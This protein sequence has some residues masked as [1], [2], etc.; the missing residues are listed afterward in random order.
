[1]NVWDG[2]KQRSTHLATSAVVA[3]VFVAGFAL[4]SQHSVGAQSPFQPPEGA[5]EDF[6]AFW[7]VYNLIQDNYVDP[8]GDELDQTK[9]VDGAIRGMMDSLGDQ[10]SGY[11]DAEMFPMINQELEGEIQ[12]IGVT[13]QT[14]EDTGAIQ[15]VSVMSDSPAQAAGIQTGDIFARVDGEDATVMNQMELAQ[16]VRGPEGSTVQITMLRDDELIDFEV[17]RARIVIPMIESQVIDDTIGYV[18]LNQFGPTARPDIDAAIE[19]M[20]T[21]SLEG[22]I[23]DLRGNPG[24]LLSSAIDVGSAFVDEG[25]ILIE[26]FGGGREQIFDANGSYLNLDIPLVVLVDE[27]SASASELVAGA[28]QDNEQATIIGETTFGKGTVQTWQPLVNGGGVRLTVARWLTPDRHWIHEFGITPDYIVEWNPTTSEEAND[29][30]QDVQLHAAIDY[31]L[32]G[33]VPQPSVVEQSADP[34]ALAG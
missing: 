17:E 8:E 14:V 19:E 25:P 11:M 27:S 28:L 2:L 32:H 3:I 13:I 1:M 29:P 21:D 33:T 31:L 12:G 23:F 30:A 16:H 20:D 24:G 26:D 15:V 4:G 7:Q 18:R 10:F 9:L 22:M 6:R 34:L 5:E